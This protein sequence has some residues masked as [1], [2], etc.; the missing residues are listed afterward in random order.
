MVFLFEFLLA[1][2]F[3]LLEEERMMEGDQVCLSKYS[4]DSL[5]VALC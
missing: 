1:G 5:V 4:V 3:V 2:H